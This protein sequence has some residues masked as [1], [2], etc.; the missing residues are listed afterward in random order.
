MLSWRATKAKPLRSSNGMWSVPTAAM[1]AWLRLTRAT[2]IVL[3]ASTLDGQIHTSTDGGKTWQI[4][5]NLNRPQLV[6]DQLSVD[7]R[8]SK[9]IYALR[10]S[11]QRAGRIFQ[12]NRRRRD[13]EGKQRFEKRINSRDGAI[14]FRPE[15][16]LG[17]HGQRRLDFKRFGRKFQT[18]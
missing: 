5:V 6:L 16:H 13:L 7:L 11:P 3:Y 8:D 12:I 14:V 18:H 15:C 1:S 2:K 9:I 17:R 10:S 4:L